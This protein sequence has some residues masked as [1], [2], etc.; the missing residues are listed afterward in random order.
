M[1]RHG[2]IFVHIQLGYEKNS[3]RT[4]TVWAFIIFCLAVK[5]TAL[6]FQADFNLRMGYVAALDK[7][8]YNEE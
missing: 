7:T 4:S 6:V 3:R 2:Y 1:I 5:F 8:A